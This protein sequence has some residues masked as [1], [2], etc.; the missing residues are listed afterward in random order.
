M[1]ISS[2][3]PEG[4]IK[5]DMVET[6]ANTA[7]HSSPYDYRPIIEKVVWDVVDE[8]FTVNS[9]FSSAHL[10]DFGEPIGFWD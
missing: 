9:L 8:I 6:G 4:A 7:F 2:F 10:G 1:R 5:W 3:T